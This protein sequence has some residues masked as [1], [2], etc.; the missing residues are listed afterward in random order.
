MGLHF[1]YCWF[2]PSPPPPPPREQRPC[3]NNSWCCFRNFWN[4]VLFCP[5]VDTP[6]LVRTTLG[7]VSV[8]VC[9]FGVVFAK[10]GEGTLASAAVCV[11]ILLGAQAVWGCKGHGW[12]TSCPR[13]SATT[14]EINNCQTEVF[15]T[16]TIP[17]F[18]E[19]FAQ[20][21]LHRLHMFS[22]QFISFGAVVCG[23]GGGGDLEAAGVQCTKRNRICS[24]WT[25]SDLGSVTNVS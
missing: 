7:V 13:F 19:T 22:P 9:D 3:Q 1:S 8:K 23:Q 21:V 4:Y 11:L 20:H 10:R 5:F 15:N 25:Y 12:C 24:L 14:A 16:V 2:V 17:F 6:P 18:Q